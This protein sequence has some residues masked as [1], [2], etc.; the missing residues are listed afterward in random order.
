MSNESSSS[1]SGIGFVG[2]L[3]ILF[4]GLKLGGVIDWAWI[5]VLSPIWITALLTIVILG[6]VFGF[7]VLKDRLASNRLKGRK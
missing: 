7:L 2:M 1:S 4:I 3:A 6:L 5:W